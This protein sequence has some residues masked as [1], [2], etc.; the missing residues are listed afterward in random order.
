M[1]KPA[2]QKTGGHHRQ[3]F[4]HAHRPGYPAGA[5]CLAALQK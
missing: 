5:F 4:P 1:A 2:L 3:D